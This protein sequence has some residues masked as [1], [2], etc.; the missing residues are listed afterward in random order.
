MLDIM[1]EVPSTGAPINEVVINEEIDQKAAAAPH[2]PE[3][4]G[5][6]G[7]GIGVLI[8]AFASHGV[9]E[10]VIASL[11]GW[12]CCRSPVGSMMFW[13][14]ALPGRPVVV[15]RQRPDE[16]A[17]RRPTRLPTAPV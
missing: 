14:V 10:W 12:P 1:Y 13:S 5:G 7:W 9:F 2:V 17:T 3:G 11:A 16:L 6:S 15:G 8:Q 4:S